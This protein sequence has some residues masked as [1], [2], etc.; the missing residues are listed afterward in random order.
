MTQTGGALLAQRVIPRRSGKSSARPSHWRG[1]ESRPSLRAPRWSSW[2]SQLNAVKRRR[3]S[4]PSVGIGFTRSGA[5]VRIRYA[6]WTRRR[7]MAKF[8]WSLRLRLR[9]AAVKLVSAI[10]FGRAFYVAN[11]R[12]A[13]DERVLR[14]PLLKRQRRRRNAFQFVIEFLAYCRWWESAWR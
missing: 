9:A 12:V 5:K 14:C 1:R 11:T 8:Y 3:S 6:T 7:S 2:Y 4:T 10:T 13:N